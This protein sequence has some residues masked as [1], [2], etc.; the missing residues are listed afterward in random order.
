MDNIYKRLEESKT[1]IEDNIKGLDTHAKELFNLIEKTLIDLSSLTTLL[2]KINE[3]MEVFNRMRDIIRN[4]KNEYYKT[5]NIEN[6]KIESDKYMEIV[7][8]YTIKK[9]RTIANSIL[10]GEEAL[11]VDINIEEGSDSGDFT[12]F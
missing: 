5:L 11:N 6:W 7:N 8:Y 12:L 2:T 3:I 1:I 10:S 4:K 9:E